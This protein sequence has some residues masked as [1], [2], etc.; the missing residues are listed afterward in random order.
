MGESRSN[1]EVQWYRDDSLT[2]PIS[3][4]PN[5]KVH[6]QGGALLLMDLSPQDSGNYTAV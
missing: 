6:Y 4:D 3:T 2:Q 1:D 5:Q